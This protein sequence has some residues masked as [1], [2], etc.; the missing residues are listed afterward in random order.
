MQRPPD[1]H[2]QGRTPELTTPGQS[3]A[4]RSPAGGRGRETAAARRRGLPRTGTPRTGHESRARHPP[5]AGSTG[6]IDGAIRSRSAWDVTGIEPVGPYPRTPTAAPP[7]PAG[8]PADVEPRTPRRALGRAAAHA[9]AARPRPRLRRDRNHRPPRPAALPGPAPP[10]P[11]PRPAGVTAPHHE[12]RDPQTASHR[13]DAG[14]AR[15]E[16][17]PA[18][19]KSES[20][21]PSW[22]PSSHSAAT[23]SEGGRAPPDH[24]PYLRI[25]ARRPRAAPRP[26]PPRPAPRQQDRTATAKLPFGGARPRDPR[27]GLRALHRANPPSPEPTSPGR[28]APDDLTR[29]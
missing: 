21:T 28:G 13:S 5:T 29:R 2:P 8:P 22:P 25:R 12:G 24:R 17:S 14:A 3:R 9:P 27:S 23:D 20:R 26:H 15:A 7:G 6:P 11:R 1:L 18:S 10:N 19:A 4:G 16:A